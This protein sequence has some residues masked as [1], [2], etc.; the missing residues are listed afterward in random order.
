MWDFLYF[1]KNTFKNLYMCHIK[2]ILSWATSGP[3]NIEPWEHRDA[4]VYDNFQ[5]YARAQYAYLVCL[6]NPRHLFMYLCLR[7][8]WKVSPRNI[9]PEKQLS[10]RLNNTIVKYTR[11]WSA[12]LAKIR[13]EDPDVLIWS[14]YYLRQCKHY[15]SNCQETSVCAVSWSLISTVCS[16][17]LS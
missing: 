9:C 10:P 17:Y 5:H 13:R 1:F 12:K 15:T 4:P 14:Q 8:H 3:G 6:C 2:R 7:G 11:V 16:L